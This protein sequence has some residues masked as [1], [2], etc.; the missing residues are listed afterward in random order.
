MAGHLSL[1]FQPTSCRMNTATEH[2]AHP[3]FRAAKVME[4]PTIVSKNAPD[5]VNFY[6][7]V[8]PRLGL[9]PNATGRER[10]TS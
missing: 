2:L 9:N 8:V 1:C 3:C 7:E 10:T 5:H 4:S 6:P